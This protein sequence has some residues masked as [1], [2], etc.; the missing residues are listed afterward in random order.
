[1]NENQNS[2]KH[3][4]GHGEGLISAISVGAVFI[5]IGIV[6][7]TT[8]D[9][10]AKIGAFFQDITTLSFPFPANSSSTISLLGPLNPASH[11][12]VYT[13]LI[14]FDLAVGILQILILALRLSMHSPTGKT[15]ET[16]GNLIFW[17]GAAVLVNMF[18]AAGTINGWFEYWGAFIVLIGV[19]MVARAIVY[20]AKR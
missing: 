18:L 11:G 19:T 10:P 4:H 7:T 9:L 3:S 12:I 17:L 16:V 20:F 2:H 5:I 6:F 14:Q 15:A 8:P 1:L 13:A